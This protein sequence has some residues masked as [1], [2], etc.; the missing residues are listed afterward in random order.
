[1][2]SDRNV[3]ISELRTNDSTLVGYK[4]DNMETFNFKNKESPKNIS[5][6]MSMYYN[7]ES[8]DLLSESSFD[9]T[10]KPQNAINDY[11]ENIVKVKGIFHLNSFTFLIVTR[12][13]LK[14]INQ[15]KLL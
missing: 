9:L 12:G 10:N 4:S 7:D 3:L 13:D 11:K 1:M 6:D 14:F 5:C 2:L 8:F 15:G